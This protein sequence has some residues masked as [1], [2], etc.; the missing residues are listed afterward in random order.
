MGN[1]RCKHL[2]CAATA[3]R[4]GTSIADEMAALAGLLEAYE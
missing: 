3:E 2:S 1:G 4:E